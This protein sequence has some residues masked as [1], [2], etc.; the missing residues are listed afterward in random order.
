MTALHNSIRQS[1]LSL[2]GLGWILTVC[3][4]AM[5][6]VP[7]SFDNVLFVDGLAYASIARNMALGQGSFWQPHFADSF[8]LT[9]N[10]LCSF[11]CEHPPLMFGMQSLLFRIF[12]DS[13]AVENLYNAIILFASVFLIS[14]IWKVLFRN[15][16]AIKNQSWLPVFLWYG[17]RIVWWSVP[18]NLLDTTMAVFCLAACYFQLKAFTQN[19]FRAAYWILA[20]IMIVLACLTKGP[21]GLFPLAFPLIYTIIYERR[22]WRKG[23]T[24]LA[25]VGCS[26]LLLAGLILLYPPAKLLISNY[27]QG[28]I[29]MALLKKREK[30]SGDWT[31]H[32]Y[33]P[34]LLIKNIIPHLLLVT[35]LFVTNKLSKIDIQFS[36]SVRRAA[37]LAFLITISI[38]L[39]MMASVKQGDYYLMPALP[40][41]GLFFAA[42]AVPMLLALFQKSER[43]PQFV[44]IVISVCLFSAMVYRLINPD[45]DRACEI[46][47]DLKK[48]V[49]ANARIYL[50]PPITMFS[51]LHTPFQRYARLSI[52]FDPNETRY[53]FFDHETK[54]TFDSISNTKNYQIIPLVHG[55]HL[56][57]RRK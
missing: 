24:G 28:Q 31:A 12:G 40:F 32:F 27:F 25:I 11:F 14:T 42:C 2:P 48:H 20:G 41:V 3:F 16:I 1:L 9:H 37:Q 21:V 44:M 19:R 50:P 10:N 46:A 34:K 29:L 15:D 47:N 51:E 5:T 4:I 7:R 23:L 30:V 35:G 54:A 56:A 33:L 52:A 13:P 8:W 55:T 6:F 17:L 45:K 53:L 43:L 49:P 22:N 26:F 36:Q 38:L 18:N 57:I 39:P